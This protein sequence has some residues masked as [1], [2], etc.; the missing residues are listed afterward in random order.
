MIADRIYQES[1]LAP[2]C[3]TSTGGPQIPSLSS[4]FLTPRSCHCRHQNR[5]LYSSA[6]LP[7]T[8][9][10]LLYL[11]HPLAGFPG[12]TAELRD[13]WEETSFRLERL[14]AAVQCVDQEQN[15]LSRRQIPKWTVP[16]TPSWTPDSVLAS[17]SK[18][19]VAIIRYSSNQDS[20]PTR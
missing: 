6:T 13:E 7:D 8:A 20:P 4:L 5:P 10:C 3:C 16:Y 2:D 14:Q 12:R 11:A 15:G 9:V 18:A 1:M 17:T 19:Q